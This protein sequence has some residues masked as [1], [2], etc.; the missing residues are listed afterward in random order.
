MSI[1]CIAPANKK[2][3]S[4]SEDL[5]KNLIFLQ[6]E[7]CKRRRGPLKEL[8]FHKNIT[9]MKIEYLSLRKNYLKKVNFVKYFINLWYLDVRDN[10]VKNFI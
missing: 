10:P 1:I 6:P 3:S 9:F 2:M 8:D 4:E 7:V 5:V